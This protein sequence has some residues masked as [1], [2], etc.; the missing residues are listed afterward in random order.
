M[1]YG[2]PMTRLHIVALAACVSICGACSASGADDAAPATAAACEA[3]RNTQRAAVET[4]YAAGE[5][6]D[7]TGADLEAAGYL[8]DYDETLYVIVPGFDGA[9]SSAQPAD[10]CLG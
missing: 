8:T 2:A 7:P 6:G 10:P 4:W 3:A 1:T 5:P 9:R